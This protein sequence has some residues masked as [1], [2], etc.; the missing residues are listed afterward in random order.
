MKRVLSMVLS[1]V[2]IAAIFPM[3]DFKADAAPVLDPRVEAAIQWAVNIA[4]DDRH[5]YSQ[6]NRNGPDYDCSSL[7]SSAFKNGGF[8]VSGSLSTST[9]STPFMRAGFTRYKKGAVT[10]QR[11]DILL[12]PGSHVELYL[13]DDTCVGAHSNYDGRTGDSSGKEIAVRN[14]K[15]CSFCRNKGYTYVLRF[16]SEE[17]IASYDFIYNGG[18]A[19]APQDQDL[20]Q[21][22]L[23]LDECQLANPGYERTGYFCSGFTVERG[24]KDKESKWMVDGE[25][26]R[27]QAEID[28]N[29]YT[30][31]VYPYYHMIKIDDDWIED[32]DGDATYTIHLEWTPG[33]IPAGDLNI[34]GI[35]DMDD[36]VHLLFNLNFDLAYPVDQPADFDN[37]GEVDTD[38]AIYLLFHINFPEAYPLF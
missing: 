25:G 37:S 33:E 38:D 1:L 36:A 15:N 14:I 30:K 11:G 6:A 10:I 27:T 9:M 5:G 35:V 23:V 19:K 7:V 20:I 8:P 26:W 24:E 22:M 28:A 21:N 12:K 18:E 29:G 3:T 4:E 16:I 34:D 2:L 32:L 31:T 17:V 13:G